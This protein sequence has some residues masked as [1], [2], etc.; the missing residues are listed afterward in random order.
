MTIKSAFR[1]R[2]ARAQKAS[3]FSEEQQKEN[4]RLWEWTMESNIRVWDEL[5]KESRTKTDWN[6]FAKYVMTEIQ[7]Y[8]K[9]MREV[10]EEINKEVK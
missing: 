5:A 7:T 4:G 1:E 8:A 3:A 2:Y 9:I 10:K 6:N